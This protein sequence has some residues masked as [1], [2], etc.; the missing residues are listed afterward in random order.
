MAGEPA[1]RL[2]RGV[3]VGGGGGAAAGLGAPRKEG[4]SL[5]AGPCRRSGGGCLVPIPPSRQPS[6]AGL[7]WVPAA[8]GG[9]RPLSNRSQKKEGAGAAER[10]PVGRD[11]K[12]GRVPAARALLTGPTVRVRWMG[13]IGGQ[14]CK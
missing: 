12:R 8:G 6:R 11:Q 4:L 3:G 13:I 14:G 7:T 2:P 5:G 10:T 1:A 9:R